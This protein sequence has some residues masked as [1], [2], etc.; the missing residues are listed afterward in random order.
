MRLNRAVRLA[1]PV[2]PPLFFLVS[3]AALGVSANWLVSF[4]S[5]NYAADSRPPSSVPIQVMAQS[6]GMPT[7][8]ANASWLSRPVSCNGPLPRNRQPSPLDAGPLPIRL[9]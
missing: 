3:S 5:Q 6:S 1:R 8:L 4:A 9:A 7:A 2:V